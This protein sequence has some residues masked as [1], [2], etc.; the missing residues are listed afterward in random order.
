[1][2]CE[3]YRDLISNHTRIFGEINQDVPRNSTNHCPEAADAVNDYLTS[4]EVTPIVAGGFIEFRQSS[5]VSYHRRSLGQIKRSIRNCHHRVIR[6][7]RNASQMEENG[8]TV[9]HYFVMFRFR[10]KI[11]VA[12]AYAPPVLTENVSDYLQ[13][14]VYSHLELA[15]RNYDIETVDLM[16]EPI[17]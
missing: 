1:M 5:R 2:A 9:H 11:Y 3:H 7:V 14:V 12:D 6:A 15:S 13:S 4:G 10:S 16:A 8:L 17:F